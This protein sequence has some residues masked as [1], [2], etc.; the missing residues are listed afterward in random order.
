MKTHYEV[1]Y[2][3]QNREYKH[4]I[5]FENKHDAVTLYDQLRLSKVD[6]NCNPRLYKCEVAGDNTRRFDMTEAHEQELQ[7]ASDLIKLFL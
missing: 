6:C 4:I 3:P 2:E 5:A 1:E 7:T